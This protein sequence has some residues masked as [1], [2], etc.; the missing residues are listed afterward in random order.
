MELK[1]K[2]RDLRASNALELVGAARP[3]R[4]AHDSRGAAATVAMPYIRQG[5]V[6]ERLSPWQL[7]FYVDFFRRLFRI[8]K[9]FFYTLFSPDAAGVKKSK[10]R[11]GGGQGAWGEALGAEG[12]GEG[13]AEEGEAVVRGG[14]LEG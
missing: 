13:E 10:G 7:A 8:I 6:V 12:V 14:G 2:H 3:V 5:E 11:G 4:L 1:L 9:M